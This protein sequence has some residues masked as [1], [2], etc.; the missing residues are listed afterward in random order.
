MPGQLISVA[1]LIGRP[2]R[3]PTGTQV[4]RVDDIT[5][6]WTTGDAYPPVT[7]MVGRVGRGLAFV[8]IGSITL[9]QTQV[10]LRTSRLVVDAPIRQA[11]DVA[12]ARDVLDHQLVDTA[13]VQVVRAA[14]IYLA[15]APDGLRLAGVDV[16][17]RT[18]LRRLPL[19]DHNRR[20]VPGR[21]IAW[22]E[23]QAFAPRSVDGVSQ[24]GGGAASPAAAA[25]QVGGS[26]RMAVSAG[27]LHTLGPA[28]V[29]AVLAELGRGQQSQL[30]T[31]TD[32]TT[33]AAALSGMR[34]GPRKALLAGLARQPRATL[35]ALLPEETDR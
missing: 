30:V 11:G 31:L 23:L 6:K 19:R 25:G 28:E 18:L 5:V 32:P 4:G 9:S 33:A 7:G 2:L 1:G 21:V 13:G 22:A 10:R 14:D 26:V 17:L 16:S 27:D 3:D 34:L 8:D 20:A 35:E 24:A 29:A 12:L 15:V